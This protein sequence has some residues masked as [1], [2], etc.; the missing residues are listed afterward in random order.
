MLSQLDHEVLRKLPGDVIQ[1]CLVTRDHKRTM[2]SLIKLGIGPWRVYEFGQQTTS[3]TSYRGQPHWFSAVM[4][5]AG[6]TNM[7]WEVVEPTGGTSIFE[8]V[9]VQKGEGV[10]H[11]GLNLDGCSFAH[12]LA[13]FATRG[14]VIAQ[15]G[16]VWGGDTTFAFINTYDALGIYLELTDS[17]PGYTPPDPDAWY[18]APPATGARS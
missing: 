5:Y 18:P 15:S 11:L 8:D 7:M 14:F 12:A 2:D 17:P 1:T 13:D 9:L 10:H 4:A 3:D 16:R 6:S